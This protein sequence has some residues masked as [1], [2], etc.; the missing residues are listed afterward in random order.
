[1]PTDE[2]L[3]KRGSMMASKCSLCKASQEDIDHLFIHCNF[4]KALWNWV[5]SAF[6][7]SIDTTSA[8]SIIM[9]GNSLTNHQL[10]DV[11]VA[12]VVHTFSTIWFC[13]NKCRFKDVV[14][15]FR[16]A[17]L[18]IQR[19]TSVSGNCSTKTSNSC[20][21]VELLMLRKFNTALKLNKAP[22]VIEV[23]WQFPQGGWIKVNTDGSAQGAPGHAGG[24]G[25]FRDH[26]GDCLACFASYLDIQFALYAEM[27]AA[28][29]AINLAL[30]YGWS[31]LW[32]ECD[33]STVV[34][35]FNGCAKVPWKLSNDWINCKQKLPLLNFHISHIFREGNSCADKLANFGL[36]SKTN[37]FWRSIPS[38]IQEVYSRNRLGLPSYKCA[39]CLY[40]V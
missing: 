19:E 39:C 20:N 35:I 33:S 5:Q 34:D 36:E 10:Q 38:I 37:T 11:F 40:S 7:I 13:R 1:M 29:K 22:K 8:L 3:M 18:K 14:V 23:V 27:S 25:I 4:A 2:N 9:N 24:G 26:N 32:L 28:I 15:P 17:T 21:V 16:Q 31:N 30:E 6:S 12:C